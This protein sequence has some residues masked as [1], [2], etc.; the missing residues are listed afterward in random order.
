LSAGQP[1]RRG[2]R[3]EAG[4]QGRVERREEARLMGSGKSTEDCQRLP[5]ILVEM[6]GS[7]FLLFFSLLLIL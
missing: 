7:L 4:L 6:Q 5:A 2:S 1:Q 3:E